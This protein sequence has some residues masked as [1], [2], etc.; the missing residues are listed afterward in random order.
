[1]TL[2][3]NRE[4]LVRMLDALGSKD[5]DGFEACLD[6]DLRCEWPY[7]VMEGFPTELVGARRLREALQA[8]FAKF[9]PYNYRIIEMYD[10]VDPNRLIAEY[11]SHCTYLP[12]G[13]PY[14]NRYLGIFDF[15]AATITRWREYVNPL[16]VR[17]A[18]GT[19]LVWRESHGVVKNTR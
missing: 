19:D 11:S 14:S 7:A 10:L 12:R 18:L 16:I 13:V 6:K 9:T 8:S 17:E 5:F 15:R 2:P 4:L 3:A 1:M